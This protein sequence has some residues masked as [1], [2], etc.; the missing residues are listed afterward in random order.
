M[1]NR[2][3][4]VK[5]ELDKTRYFKFDMDALEKVCQMTGKGLGEFAENAKKLT[6]SDYKALIWAGL[7]HE[8]PKLDISEINKITDG[9][10]MEAIK[11]AMQAFAISLGAK[12]EDIK[13]A[14]SQAY[15][16]LAAKKANR[17][18]GKK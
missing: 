11:K 16:Q 13:K 18:H 7:L 17:Q 3:G 9:R 8:D 14:Q 5:A 4:Y 1:S 15:L 10:I 2:R 12:E 6:I